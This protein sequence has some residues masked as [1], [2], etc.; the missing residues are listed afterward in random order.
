MI[1]KLIIF[2]YPTCQEAIKNFTK[3]GKRGIVIFDQ[4]VRIHIVAISEQIRGGRD[5]TV[6]PSQ[7]ISFCDAT[8][9][10]LTQQQFHSLQRASSIFC[11]GAI[12]PLEES[13]RNLKW[14]V[15]HMGSFLKFSSTEAAT[16]ERRVTWFNWDYITFGT[17]QLVLLSY[18]FV[19]GTFFCLSVIY[20]DISHSPRLYSHF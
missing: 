6:Y 4:L 10:K 9:A 17:R 5:L 14:E 3:W 7:C 16:D 18:N 2:L 13:Q 8:F 11:L 12:R 1:S 20:W 19:T 15:S